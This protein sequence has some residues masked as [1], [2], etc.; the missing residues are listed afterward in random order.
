VV[1]ADIKGFFNA[2]N[3]DLLM[4]MLDEAAIAEKAQ[5]LD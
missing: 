5:L 4:D 1:E 3:H 2:I